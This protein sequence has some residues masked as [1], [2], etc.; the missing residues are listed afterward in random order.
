MDKVS[1]SQDSRIVAAGIDAAKSTFSVCG[2]ARGRN[3]VL[4]RTMNRVRLLVLFANLPPCTIGLEAC[5]GAH[6]LARELSALGHTV[7][8]IAA[9]FVAPHRTSGKNDRNDARA[10]VDALLHPRTRFVPIKS[11]EQQAL[12]SLQRARHGFVCERTALV[13]RIRGLLAE[14][15]VTLPKNIDLLRKLGPAAAQALPS[16]AREVIAE[17]HAHLRVLDERIAHYDRQQRI[18]ARQ[19]EPAQRL[20]EILGVGPLTALS[21]VATIGN[22]AEFKNGRQFTAWMGLVPRQWTTGG[23]VRLGHITKGGDAYLRMLYVQAAK[24]ALATAHRRQDRLSRWALTVRARR[25]FGKAVVAL[26]AKLARIAWAL[27]S[28]GERFRREGLAAA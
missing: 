16:L 12:L 4:E 7:R 22:G 28:K 3:I 23:K 6:Q 19:S 11:V 20:D 5:S 8:I 27:L 10:I 9:K 17:L 1:R 15:G 25:G 18:L 21:T 26:A 14:F 2:V 13:N 24:A